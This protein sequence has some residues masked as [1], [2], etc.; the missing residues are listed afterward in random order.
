MQLRLPATPAT[1]VTVDES[2][3]AAS[4]SMTQLLD[5]CVLSSL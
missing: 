3:A 1:S 5:P 4:L 2:V